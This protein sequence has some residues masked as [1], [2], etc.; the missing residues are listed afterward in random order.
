MTHRLHRTGR[1]LE[2]REPSSAKYCKDEIR[3]IRSSTFQF[4]SEHLV[5]GPVQVAPTALVRDLGVNLDSNMS[6][7]SHVTRLVCTCFVVLQQIR[8]IR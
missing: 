2:G 4:L 5:V 6:V 8:S 3:V 1:Q 7:R